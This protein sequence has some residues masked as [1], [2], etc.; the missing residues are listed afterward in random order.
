[1][2]VAEHECFACV[3]GSEHAI[4]TALQDGTRHEPHLFLI[5]YQEDGLG[6]SQGCRRNLWSRDVERGVEGRKVDL[7]RRA[8]ARLTV[9]PD[10]PAGLLRNAEH[11]RKP[12]P[13]ALADLFG[14]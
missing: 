9:D 5:L 1:M 12:E 13:S 3:H 2:R 6:A 8:L 10:A 7:D 14:R 4:A 11:R